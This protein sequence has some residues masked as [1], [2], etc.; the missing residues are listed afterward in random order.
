[1][2]PETDPAMITAARPAAV[3]PPGVAT[4]GSDS[5]A[6]HLTRRRGQAL[7]GVSAC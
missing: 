4:A 1:M 3:D 7:T 5:G 6:T 2:S